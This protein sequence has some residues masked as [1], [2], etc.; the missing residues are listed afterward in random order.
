MYRDVYYGHW[1]HAS[2]EHHPILQ[3]VCDKTLFVIRC[4]LLQEAIHQSQ[5]QSSL[6]AFSS[7]SLL[8]NARWTSDFL[9]KGQHWPSKICWMDDLLLESLAGR[10]SAVS[11]SYVCG[12]T[13]RPVQFPGRCVLHIS[14][15]AT[16]GRPTSVCWLSVSRNLV[17]KCV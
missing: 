16:R 6:S 15:D 12:R 13:P 4:R 1:P 5:F 3:F 17:S 9:V 7:S 14:Q 10:T 11:A 8:L 2:N